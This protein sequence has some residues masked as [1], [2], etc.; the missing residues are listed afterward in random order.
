MTA[1][2]AHHLVSRAVDVT[3][4]HYKGDHGLEP[5]KDVVAWAILMLPVATVLLYVAVLSMV[6]SLAAPSEAK[7]QQD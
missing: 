7:N 6:S 3:R 5:G 1:G 2:I 4:Q